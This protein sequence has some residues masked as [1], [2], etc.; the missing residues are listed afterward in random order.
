MLGCFDFVPFAIQSQIN[1]SGPVTDS[2][3]GAKCFKKRSLLTVRNE[4]QGFVEELAGPPSMV[5]GIFECCTNQTMLFCLV[6]VL[7]QSGYTPALPQMV[8]WLDNQSRRVRFAAA[9]TLN[10]VADDR[11]GIL[12]MEL[13]SNE[14]D[15]VIPLIK[16]WWNQRP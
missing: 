8:Q 16:T 13:E 1:A 7:G 11:F 4:L 15:D 12:D 14:I 5:D 9:V 10:L 6:R 2:K 3:F